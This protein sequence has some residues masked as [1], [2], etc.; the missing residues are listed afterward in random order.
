MKSWNYNFV[1]FLILVLTSIV[2]VIFYF[3][4][5][6]L[7]KKLLE[8]ED[9]II[10]QEKYENLLKDSLTFQNQI[11]VLKENKIFLE[12]EKLFSEKEIIR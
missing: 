5:Y 1:I 9:L 7:N 12:E 10:N 11:E 4:L 6:N 3:Y 2:S 8:I